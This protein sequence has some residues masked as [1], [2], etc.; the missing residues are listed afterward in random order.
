MYLMP[1][2]MSLSFS[3]DQV[4]GCAPRGGEAD[5][6]SRGLSMG[7]ELGLLSTPWLWSVAVVVFSP[8]LHVL[9]QMLKVREAGCGS[10]E[11]D[12]EVVP[13]SVDKLS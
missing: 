10:Q 5:P 2:E 12:L 9:P 6:E 1:E 3:C 7:A 13:L 4:W 8:Q 11:Q